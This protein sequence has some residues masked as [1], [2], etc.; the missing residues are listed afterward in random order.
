MNLRICRFLYS[1]LIICSL[2]LLFKMSVTNSDNNKQLQLFYQHSVAIKQ[3]NSSYQD[4][5]SRNIKIKHNYDYRSE[6]NYIRNS[7]SKYITSVGFIC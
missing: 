6:Q 2:K 5:H 1:Q 7:G 3:F 4:I